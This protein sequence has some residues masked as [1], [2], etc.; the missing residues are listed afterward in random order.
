V[1]GERILCYWCCRFNSN[2]L[3][4]PELFGTDVFLAMAIN[5]L[6]TEDLNLK[7]PEWNTVSFQF[8]G[9]EAMAIQKEKVKHGYNFRI[10]FQ[11]E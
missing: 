9:I 7:V 11:L 3:L 4:P 10:T 5:H 8:T 2:P 6:Q 1:A